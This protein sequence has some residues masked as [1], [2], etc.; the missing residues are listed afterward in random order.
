MFM[1]SYHRG[2]R[3]VCTTG[4]RITLEPQPTGADP[5]ALT[6]DPDHDTLL[7]GEDLFDGKEN[8]LH[9]LK[10][11][12]NAEAWGSILSDMLKAVPESQ[13]MQ[14]GQLCFSCSQTAEYRLF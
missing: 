14:C 12:A 7:F 4:R 3:P 6:D 11:A 10:Q 13:A 8:S 5:S 2:G 9:A 1:I